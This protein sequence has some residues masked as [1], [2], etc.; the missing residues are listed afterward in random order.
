MA[1]S[2]V[3]V[4][5]P[6]EVA[7][8][9]Y[10]LIEEIVKSGGVVKKGSN[11]ATKAIERGFAKFVVIAEDVNPEEI[12]M[13][14]PPLCREKNV[15]YAFVPSKKEL[16]AAAG[17]DVSASAVAVVDAGKAERKMIEIIKEVEKLRGKTEE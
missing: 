3:D 15:P 1:A 7:E 17:I 14:L 10:D 9:I 12:V 16:G 5:V 8:K 13:H 11:E 6:S 2:Y 4:Q